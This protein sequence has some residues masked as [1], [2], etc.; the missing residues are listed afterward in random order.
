MDLGGLYLKL[1][2]AYCC[3]LADG[4]ELGLPLDIKTE[5]KITSGT[6]E[7]VQQG[8]CASFEKLCLK[9]MLSTDVAVQ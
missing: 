4:K 8:E 7:Q 5:P 6:I 2:T 9:A 3:I 1:G